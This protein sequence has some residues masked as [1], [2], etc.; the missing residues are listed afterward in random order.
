MA[1]HNNTGSWGEQVAREFL[2]TKGYAVMESN[3]HVG[4]KE[5]DIVATKGNRIIF[6][7]V[8]TRSS[9]FV[10]PLEAV[11]EKKIRRLTRAADSFIRSRNVIHEPQFDIIVIIGSKETGYTLDHYEDAFRA[12][13]SGSW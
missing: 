12:P 9:D 10:D 7:E 11:D 1:R 13:L 5:L 2:I 6:V 3:V 8:K 4:H